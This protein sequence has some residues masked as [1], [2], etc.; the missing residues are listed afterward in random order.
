MCWLWEKGENRKTSKEVRI[1]VG[2]N[3]E[4]NPSGIREDGKKW[5]NKSRF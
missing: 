5:S 2:D 1:Q 3:C 4:S